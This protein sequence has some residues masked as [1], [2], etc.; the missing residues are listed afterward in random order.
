MSELAFKQI[1]SQ[2]DMLSYD[3]RIKLLG[4]IVQTLQ[5]PAKTPDKESSDFDAVFGLWKDRSISVE[6]IR[7]KAWVCRR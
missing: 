1:S 3:E 6:E 5:S 7:N 4:K 2:V